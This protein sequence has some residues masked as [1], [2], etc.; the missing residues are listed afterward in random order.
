MT[1]W[2]IVIVGLCASVGMAA[3]CS[4]DE[5]LDAA[6]TYTLS[7]TNRE[8]GCN[9]EGW[10]VGATATGITLVVTQT[11]GE[12]ML[13][14][15]LSGLAGVWVD[16]V[17]GNRSL[18]GEVS[19]DEVTLTLNGTRQLTQNLCSYN[20]VATLRGEL[21][22]DVLTGSIDYTTA[23]NGSPDCGSLQGCHT[24]QDLNGTRPPTAP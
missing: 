2:A 10:T 7:V 12:R 3:S 8:N 20:V 16:L 17:L 22:G 24:R 4:S 23:T 19:G 1:P 11:A 21:H 18:Q 5:P 9:F 15:Q 14:A 13:A 6:G